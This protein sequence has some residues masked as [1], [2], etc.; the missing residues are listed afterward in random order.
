M[1]KKH[2]DERKDRYFQLHHYM[3]KT[4]AWR[5]LSAAARAVYLQIGSRYSGANNGRLALS[6]RDA[7]SECNFP[8]KPPVGPFTSW[9]TS[10]SPRRRAT[11]D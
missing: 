4:D 7:A 2:L 5:A 1:G 3:M 9:S 6:V 11:A 8:G 10:A